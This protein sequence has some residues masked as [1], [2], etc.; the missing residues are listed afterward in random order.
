MISHDIKN[1]I[2]YENGNYIINDINK[3][4]IKF[5]GEIEELIISS[6]CDKLDLS[7][8]K[9]ISLYY[10]NQYGDSIKNHILPNSLINLLCD[11]NQ[12]TQ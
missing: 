10:S 12:L 1:F 9:C 8:V 11:H 3:D 7:E 5:Y 2:K 4:N 6:K